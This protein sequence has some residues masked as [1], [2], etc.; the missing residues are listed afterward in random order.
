MDLSGTPKKIFDQALKLF[1]MQRTVL[2]PLLLNSESVDSARRSFHSILEWR[3]F[4][5]GHHIADVRIICI[6]AESNRISFEPL[7]REVE[8]HGIAVRGRAFDTS[9]PISPPALEL[10]SE[11]EKLIG[12]D[13]LVLLV[14]PGAVLVRLNALAE[15]IQEVQKQKRNICI[16]EG[17]KPTA[18]PV[19]A[20]FS[21]E[22]QAV[23]GL[24]IVAADGWAIRVR[25]SFFLPHHY[26]RWGDGGLLRGVDPLGKAINYDV[27]WL[28]GCLACAVEDRDRIVR[29]RPALWAQEEGGG[30][31]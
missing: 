5:A 1:S 19:A 28:I 20:L 21:K 29:L 24:M 15:S 4:E 26:H 25:R 14:A 3:D 10:F 17:T 6:C 12:F 30:K 16:V 7:L 8:S 22:V 27:R 18:L 13:D 9:W 2:V 31:S 11:A 23:H